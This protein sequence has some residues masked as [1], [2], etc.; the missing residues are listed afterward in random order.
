MGCSG[1]S[2]LT[3][4]GKRWRIEA[5]LQRIPS[6][7]V[8]HTRLHRGIYVSRYDLTPSGDTITTL[9]IRIKEPN[10]DYMP[11]KAA[12]TIEHIG[13]TL[14]RNKAEWKDKVIYFGPMGCMTGFYLVL[15]GDYESKDVVELLQWMFEVIADWHET[16]PGATERECGN[17][18][19]HDLQGARRVA[20]EY[21]MVLGNMAEERLHY[22]K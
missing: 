14:L 20:R 16:I 21:L 18:S 10:V 3:R 5:M 15:N 22:P 19:F 13:A 4:R 1:S 12:H 7:Q 17:A 2:K 8:D 6:F 9:D 11:P